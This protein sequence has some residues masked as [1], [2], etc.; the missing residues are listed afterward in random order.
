MLKHQLTHPQINEILGDYN[1]SQQALRTLADV[2][3]LIVD[4]EKS[5]TMEV[6][7]RIAALDASIKTRILF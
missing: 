4:M 2:G 6:K 7:K 5:A 3:Y 1:I